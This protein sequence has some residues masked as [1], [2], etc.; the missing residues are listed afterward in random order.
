MSVLSFDIL[1]SYYLNDPVSFMAVLNSSSS[2]S[3]IYKDLLAQIIH[4]INNQFNSTGSKIVRLDMDGNIM[5]SNSDGIFGNTKADVKIL[6]SRVKKVNTSEILIADALGKRAFILQV[7]TGNYVKAIESLFVDAVTE[8]DS[9]FINAVF[10]N[11]NVVLN[12]SQVIWEY[13][14]SRYVTSFDIIPVQ[15]KV[16]E[17]CDDAIR[18]SFV[19]IRQGE[20][21]QWVNNSSKPITVYSGKT[22]YD[23]FNLT[24]D[25]SVYG[26]EFTSPVLNPGETYS[27]K[28]V[29]VGSEDY[30]IYP[31]ILVGRVTI[32]RGRLNSDDE[33]IIAEND[34]FITPF[35]S[36][37]I[38]VD[39]WGNILKSIGEGYMCNPRLAQPLINGNVLVST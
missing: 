26:S 31:D 20:T 35:S 29:T 4:S 27:Y 14:S 1:R 22:S 32:T 30:F 21:I 18:N 12:L 6:S 15:T 34:G 7:S 23:Q 33:F 2:L 9:Q 3:R 28:F 19:D 38:R 16:I 8:D 13:K 5:F 11:T 37:V 36:R 10:S 24:K 17:V 39:S 25:L